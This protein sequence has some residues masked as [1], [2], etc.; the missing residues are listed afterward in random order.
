MNPQCNLAFTRICVLLVLLLCLILSTPLHAQENGVK[1][2]LTFAELTYGDG[3]QAIVADGAGGFWFGG[4]RVR[5]HYPQRAMRYRNRGLD[6]YATGRS[7]RTH[8]ERRDGHL[9]ELF[10]RQRPQQSV[11]LDAR[12][13]WQSI[14]R[15]CHALHRFSDDRWRLRSYVRHRWE[16]NYHDPSVPS[17]RW[18]AGMA[19]VSSPSS[20]RTAA[21]SSSRRI[22]ADPVTMRSRRLRWTPPVASMSPARRRAPI[23]PSRRARCRRRTPEAPT[24]KA[25]GR[26]R[27]RSSSASPR[28]ARRFSTRRF[29][30]ARAATAPT[31]SR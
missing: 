28:T 22:S 10:R 12:S 8:E 20:R 29:S 31:E 1:H 15:R 5:R 4:S 14:C 26:S 21:T 11:R 17:S 24:R 18:T 9:S 30:A 27:T 19:M 6:S 25:R 13:E 16:C 23:F 3:I 7:A 2:P